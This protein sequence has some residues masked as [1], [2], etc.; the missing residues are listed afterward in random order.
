M[1]F[2][3]VKNLEELLFSSG[4]LIGSSARQYDSPAVAKTNNNFAPTSIAITVLEYS[5]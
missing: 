4:D 1:L 2:A 5:A 3:L